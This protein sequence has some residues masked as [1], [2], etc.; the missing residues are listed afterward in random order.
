M[1]SS[2]RLRRALQL[3]QGDL[4]TLVSSPFAASA[5][6]VLALLVVGGIWLRRRQARYERMLAAEVDQIDTVEDASRQTV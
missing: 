4:T 1:A 5:Y 6:V 3:S 2:A